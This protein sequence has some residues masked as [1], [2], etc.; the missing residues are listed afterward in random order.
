[1]PIQKVDNVIVETAPANNDRT[2]RTDVH[3]DSDF[4]LCDESDVLKQFKFNIS[5]MAAGKTVTFAAGA[6]SSDV[7]VTLPAT[8]LTLGGASAQ[9]TQY[10][11]PTTGQTVTIAPT[12][13]MLICEPAGNLDALTIVFPTTPADGTLI[14]MSFGTRFVTALTLSGGGSDT[15]VSAPSD[16]GGGFLTFGYRAANA[17]WYRFGS[18]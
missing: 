13:T 4:A 9:V 12:T 3:V 16:T 18:T 6:G 14:F 15:V 8:S 5:S 17:K 10:A 7:V 11:T 2:Q 1:M